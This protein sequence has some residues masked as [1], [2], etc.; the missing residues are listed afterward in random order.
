MAKN[1]NC[2]SKLL[3]L[4]ATV[5]AVGGACYVFRDKIKNSPLYKTALD[6]AYDLYDKWKDRQ[7]D[8]DSFD[9]FD[10]DEDDDFEDIFSEEDKSEREYTSITI[11]AKE[12]TSSTDVADDSA[13]TDNTE[14]DKTPDT[15][16]DTVSAEVEV[17]AASD[18]EAPDE[19]VSSIPQVEESDVT[20]TT[21]AVIPT[22]DFGTST[23]SDDE[24]EVLGYENEGLSDV[25]E[26][27]DVLE[28]Q[29]KLDF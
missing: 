2:F 24:P 8:D 19:E 6:K 9:D 18:T 20:Y 7:S 5:A 15:S 25:S 28:E 22:I 1:K 4:T 23:T 27:P 3:A 12:D 17:P 26:D 13:I 29:D 16:E 10:F 11:N 21:D 14:D